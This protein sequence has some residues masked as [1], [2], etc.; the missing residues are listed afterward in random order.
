[1]NITQKIM[2]VAIASG[3]R[4]FKVLLTITITGRAIIRGPI[5]TIFDFMISCHTLDRL[6]A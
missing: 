4:V 6:E 5:G 1:M 3:R 2:P